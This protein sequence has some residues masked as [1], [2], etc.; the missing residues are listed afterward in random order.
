MSVPSVT[1]RL[2]FWWWT[3][4]SRFDR[5]ALQGDASANGAEDVRPEARNVRSVS[6]GETQSPRRLNGEYK[7]SSIFLLDRG[8][9]VGLDQFLIMRA[10]FTKAQKKLRSVIDAIPKVREID[11]VSSY[12]PA[13]PSK[14]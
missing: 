10:R 5:L 6:I 4:Y 8:G 1:A 13:V 12:R 2:L 9:G 3:L 11:I 14:R 7:K